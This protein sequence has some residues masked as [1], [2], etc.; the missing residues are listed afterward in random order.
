MA[1]FPSVANSVG[2]IIE[3]ARERLHTNT[4]FLFLGRRGSKE[5][6][7]IRVSVLR[8]LWSALVNNTAEGDVLST[9]YVTG[10]D[11]IEALREASTNIRSFLKR[12]TP[13]L[14][15]VKH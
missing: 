6:D 9:D 4:Y 12:G 15:T 1:S 3:L 7:F 14:I 10:V 11:N 2:L 5:N 8:T 13:T